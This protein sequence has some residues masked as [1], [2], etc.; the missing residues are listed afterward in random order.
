M[1]F[2]G[3]EFRKSGEVTPTPASVAV[4]LDDTRK[5]LALIIT[6]WGM[7]CVVAISVTAI[8]WSPP[9]SKRCRKP[10]W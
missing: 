8:V 3:Y 1:T 10:Q 7:I 4:Q 6:V 2:F 5:R 9:S